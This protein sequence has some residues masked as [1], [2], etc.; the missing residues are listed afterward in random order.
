MLRIE[1][2]K[3]NQI[4]LQISK[5]ALNSKDAKIEIKIPGTSHFINIKKFYRLTKISFEA[6]IKKKQK[7]LYQ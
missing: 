7:K 4:L 5:T 6:T 2:E 3:K 1:V